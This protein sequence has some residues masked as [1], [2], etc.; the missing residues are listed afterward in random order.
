MDDGSLDEI[1]EEA[2]YSVY[3]DRNEDYYFRCLEKVRR[4]VII[5]FNFYAFIANVFWLSYRKMYWEFAIIS[6]III[7]LAIFSIMFDV[8]FLLLYFSTC[9]ILGF[10]ANYLYIRKAIKI[11]EKSEEYERIGDRFTYLRKKGGISFFLLQFILPT[12][13]FLIIV[14]LISLF[15]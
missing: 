13:I 7:S 2:L 8:S 4:G 14:L 11:V 5:D 12:I 10:I 9:F 15:I 6:L 1:K 3:F